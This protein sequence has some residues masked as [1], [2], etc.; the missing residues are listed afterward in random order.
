MSLYQ[1][2]KIF[3][4]KSLGENHSKNVISSGLCSSHI[5]G[6][7]CVCS[8][9]EVCGKGLLYPFKYMCI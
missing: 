1:L 8:L 3:V 5:Q 9:A 2:C 4:V 6:H 7:D